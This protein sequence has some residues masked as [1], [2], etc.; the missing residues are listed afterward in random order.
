M[1]YI[2]KITNI[3][4]NKIYIGLTMTTIEQRWQSHIKTAYSKNSKDYNNLLK[5]A[6]RKYGKENFIIEQIDA[7][8]TLEELKEKEKYWI[9][10]YNSFCLLQDSWG[11]NL[12]RGGDSPTHEQDCIKIYRVN[13]LTGEKVESFNSITDAERKYQ[14]GI[15]EIINKQRNT[16]IPFGYTWLKEDEEYDQN[17]IFIRYNIICKLDLDGKLKEYYINAQNASNENNCSRGNISSCL[18]NTRGQAG[19]FQWCY[20]KDLQHK[21]NKPYINQRIIKTQKK[22]GQYDLCNNLINIWDSLTLA[23]N[24]TNTDISKI[25]MV[26]NNKRKTANGFKWKFINGEEGLYK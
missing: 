11:Y 23:A 15:N 9:K 26:C 21:L 24:E 5:K 18:V 1:G 10:H 7:A 14:R 16:Q 8:D 20:Y 13:I 12:T 19:G 6:I 25:S 4:N 2:Y 22:V 17:E 3:I